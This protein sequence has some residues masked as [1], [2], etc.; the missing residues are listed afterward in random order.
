MTEESGDNPGVDIPP[1]V[2]ILAAI[3]LGYLLHKY[4]PLA[5]DLPFALEISGLF[6]A[7]ALFLL[8]WAIWSFL[9]FNTTILP[10]RSNRVLIQ[11]GPFRYSRNPVYLAFLLIQTA[12]AIATGNGWILL[13]LPLNWY[14]LETRVICREEAYLLRTFGEDYTDYRAKV[15]R[16]I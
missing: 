5:L 12:V 2:Y 10:H 14:L 13:L 6:L 15:R 3:G 4:R 16:W 1:P 11:S 7:A 9:H 8:G